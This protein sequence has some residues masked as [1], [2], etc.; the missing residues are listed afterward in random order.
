MDREFSPASDAFAID[1]VQFAIG[2]WAPTRVN[3]LMVF[4]GTGFRLGRGGGAELGRGG[5][6]LTG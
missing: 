4:V 3:I 2:F 5:G 6:S 1:L